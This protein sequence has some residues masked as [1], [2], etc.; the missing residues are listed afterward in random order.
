MNNVQVTFPTSNQNN[1][2]YLFRNDVPSIQFT[3]NL[4]M[5][6]LYVYAFRIIQ[7]KVVKRLK[8]FT[9]ILETTLHRIIHKTRELQALKH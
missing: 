9:L 6:S 3:T 1:Y 5:A 7:G 8:S 4:Q 2:N